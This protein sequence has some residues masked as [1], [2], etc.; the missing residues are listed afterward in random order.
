MHLIGIDQY[1]NSDIAY[2][3]CF[4]AVVTPNHRE[5]SFQGHKTFCI[6]RSTCK[7]V[8]CKKIWASESEFFY[9]Q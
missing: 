2:G 5:I 4:L 7:S 8:F 9:Q 1:I 6:N 3:C